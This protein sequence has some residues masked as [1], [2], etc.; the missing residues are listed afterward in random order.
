[1]KGVSFSVGIWLGLLAS[2]RGSSG[3]IDELS[4]K[5]LVIDGEDKR[6]KA[7]PVAKYSATRGP[8]RLIIDIKDSVEMIVT[9]E[10]VDWEPAGDQS[11]AEWQD[12][13]PLLFKYTL[14]NDCTIS[15]VDQDRFSRVI[16]DLKSEGFSH[17]RG[18]LSAFEY[19]DIVDAIRLGPIVLSPPAKVT[20][21]FLSVGVPHTHFLRHDAGLTYILRAL[22]D[23]HIFVG[24]S[25]EDDN[26]HP[27]E[28]TISVI[29]P[30]RFDESGTITIGVSD[31][32]SEEARLVKKSFQLAS[33]PSFSDWKFQ[34]VP[35]SEALYMGDL[36]L[37]ADEGTVDIKLE[38][39]EPI[40]SNKDEG[41]A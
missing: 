3:L 27:R 40:Y 30:Y 4:W 19:L 33:G 26:E 17:F 14:G 31:N 35:M 12:S 24:V 9:V 32:D 38:Q 28:T 20:N 36:I 10:V 1:M 18:A 6:C 16:D 29:L 34:Y 5:D 7:I 11:V 39:R 25:V 22:N 37:F 21:D 15:L 8:L 13:P 41:V 2:T 23:S